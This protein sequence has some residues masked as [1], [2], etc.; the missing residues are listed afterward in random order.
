MHGNDREADLAT[1][2]AADTAYLLW[3]L[4]RHFGTASSATVPEPSTGEGV[5]AAARLNKVGNL[6][7]T[8]SEVFDAKQ[9]VR[10]RSMIDDYRRR[11]IRLNSATLGAL[12]E[13]A[14]VLDEAGIPF[15]VVKGPLQQNV[16]YGSYF[17][18]P[19][20]DVD[21]LVAPQRFAE[22][23]AALGAIGFAVERRSRSLW[24][25]I[26][27]GE[28]H[29]V[30]ARQPVAT[31]DLHH[32]LGQP[33]SPGPRDTA[34]FLRNRVT[35]EFSGR[36]IPV[37]SAPYA[38]L[39]V[40][41]SIAK[42]LFHREAS[43]GYVCDLWRTLAL[44]SAADQ[45]NLSVMAQGQG[46]GPTLLL[47]VRAANVLIGG[48]MA[49]PLSAN[50]ARFLPSISDDDL[51]RHVVEPWDP[52]LEW[53]KRRQVLW[54]LCGRR[55]AGYAREVSWATSSE[56]GRRLLEPSTPHHAMLKS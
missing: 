32:R 45:D 27:L 1:P 2:T 10:L 4:R 12:L 14:E 44:M 17:I 24:W 34:A 41:V 56:I 29:L 19:S 8:Y 15:A 46:L 7:H 5:Y 20:G 28:Q 26:F 50:A 3:A 22:A 11:T 33:G 9:A 48:S 51:I 6:I 31:V 36:P 35:T 52:A 53:P 42:A 49:T 47:A 30:R 25:R 54:E 37:L 38:A 16:I 13:V 55:M 40:A 23:S 39:L 43:G 21:L 18:K